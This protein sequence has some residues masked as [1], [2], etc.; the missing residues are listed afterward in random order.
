MAILAYW[1]NGTIPWLTAK[2][3]KSFELDG[4]IMAITEEGARKGSRI[5]PAGSILILVR[6]MTLFKDVPLGLTTRPVAFGQDLKALVPKAGINPRFLAWKLVSQKNNLMNLVDSAGHGT[7]RLSTDLLAALPLPLPPLAEQEAIVEVLD[8][9][10]GAVRAADALIQKKLAYKKALAEA[11]LTGRWRFPAFSTSWGEHYLGDLFDERVE[12]N[13]TGLRLL[14][15]TGANGVVDRDTLAKR[16][17]SSEDKSKY[18]RV[19]SGD[20]AYN[21]MR[22][23]QGVFGLSLLEGIVSP[24]YTVCIPRVNLIEPRFVEQFFKLPRVINHFKR[25]SQ[26]L[27]DDTL[28]LKFHQF[29]EIRVTIPSLEEQRRIADALGA[30]DNEL[31]LRRRQREA[32][33]EQKKGLMQ[34]LLTGEVRLKEFRG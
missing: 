10:E 1:E 25:F 14:A 18:L 16:D 7:G 30:V 3:I 12:L 22:M 2:D 27:V 23:W 15:V 11:L 29:A 8:A 9:A 24:A 31:A 17:T 20:I 21:T 6:G 28:N 34:K 13:R 32:L 5:A 4:S 19:C 26:G 33:N